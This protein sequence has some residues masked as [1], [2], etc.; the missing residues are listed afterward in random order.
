MKKQVYNQPT[1]DIFEMQ[2]DNLMLTVSPKS[3]GSGEMH[4]PA[5]KGSDIPY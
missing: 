4:A 3:G 1:T 2:G 5:R